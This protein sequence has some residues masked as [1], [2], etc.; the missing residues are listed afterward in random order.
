MTRTIPNTATHIYFDS[1]AV[2]NKCDKDFKAIARACKPESEHH[3]KKKGVA[4]KL[5]QMMEKLDTIGRKTS[6]YIRNKGNAWMDDHCSGMWLKPNRFK[7]DKSYTP[8][9]LDA[10]KDA[11]KNL[12]V[13]LLDKLTLLSGSLN[14]MFGLAYDILP[15]HV[16]TKIVVKFAAKTGAKAIVGA[17]GGETVIIPVVMAAWTIADIMDTA[18]TLAGLMGDKGAQA[19]E[20]ILAIDNLSDKAKALLEDM[21]NE[22]AKAHANLMS[23][24]GLMDSCLRARKCLLVPYSKQNSNSGDGCCPGQ[25]GHHL[26]PDSAAEGS[27]TPYTKGGTPVMCLEGTTNDKGWGTHGNA[28]AMLKDLMKQYRGDQK[29]AGKSPNVI[30]QKEMSS[31]AVD[32]VRH[33]GAALQCDKDC[34]LA[35]LNAYYSCPDGMSPKDGTGPMPKM[36]EPLPDTEIL[37]N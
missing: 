25:T 20:A 21:V 23:L 16:V 22:P 15:E 36:P 14:D 1:A 13:D 12:D 24:L 2:K 10:I 33:S 8:E 27:C 18:T 31:N 19:L 37:E 3:K 32:A 28:H 11:I 7:D 34:L 6:G 4:G 26:I 17:V 35:Q 29:T 30:S 9:Q 5:S